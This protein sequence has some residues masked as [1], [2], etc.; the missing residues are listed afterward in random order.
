MKTIIESLQWCKSSG[1]TT[2]DS[3]K[4][5]CQKDK[6]KKCNLLFV[7][8]ASL[9]FILL[10]SGKFSEKSTCKTLT[11]SVYLASFKFCR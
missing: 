4:S 5:L 10:K 6:E 8:M 11:E 7:L 3:H 2:A 1:I 9:Y